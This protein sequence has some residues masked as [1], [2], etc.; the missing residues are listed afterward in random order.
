M[1]EAQRRRGRP[2][3]TDKDASIRDATWQLLAERGYDGL[4]F[5]GVAEIV[6]CSRATLY[7]RYATKAELIAAILDSTSRSVEPDLPPEMS[8]RDALIAHSLAGAIYLSGH[9]GP[10]LISLGFVAAK[11]PELVAAITGH[12]SHEL[13]YYRLELRK[14]FP[15]V[16]PEEID[17]ACSTL[18]G[19]IVY[20]V[21]LA[22]QELPRRRIEQLVDQAIRMLEDVA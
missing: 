4:T 10:A 14:L 12:V 11:I 6:G 7:R 5:E 8:P 22:Q 19:G 18:L 21:A 3:D 1:I 13:E 16:A 20:H 9:R 17:F 15:S 2:R